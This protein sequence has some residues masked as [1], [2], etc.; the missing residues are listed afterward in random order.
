MPHNGYIEALDND[1]DGASEVLF[2]YDYEGEVVASVDNYE[3]K[4]NFAFS[5]IFEFSAMPFTY[6]LLFLFFWIAIS[7]CCWIHSS[8]SFPDVLMNFFASFGKFI[9]M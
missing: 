7:I 8:T 3:E 5:K 2:I 1:N 9:C 4:I 6:L